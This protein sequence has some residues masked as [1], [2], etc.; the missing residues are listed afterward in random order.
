MRCCIP[1]A[2]STFPRRTLLVADA[3][4]GK[5]VSFRKLGVPVPRGTTGGTLAKLDAAIADTRRAR[6]LPR[7]LP[8]FGALARAGTLGVLQAWR[9]APSRTWR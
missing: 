6:R 9:E 8:A 7:R 5:A 4:F 3:H 1:P 2:P